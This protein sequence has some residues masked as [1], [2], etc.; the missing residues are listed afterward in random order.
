MFK[1]IPFPLVTSVLQFYFTVH[2]IKHLYHILNVIKHLCH[3]LNTGQQALHVDELSFKMIWSHSAVLRASQ[4]YSFFFFFCCYKA[5]A[6]IYVKCKL[7]QAVTSF[8]LESKFLP[9]LISMQRTTHLPLWTMSFLWHQWIA[10][11]SW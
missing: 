3:I 8:P 9:R 6:Y 2:V 1:K 11:I 10:L 4:I 5:I 7:F